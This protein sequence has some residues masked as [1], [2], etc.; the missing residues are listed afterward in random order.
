MYKGLSALN[1]A[2]FKNKQNV[3]L[4]ENKTLQMHTEMAQK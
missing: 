4:S 2:P 1:K 3:R